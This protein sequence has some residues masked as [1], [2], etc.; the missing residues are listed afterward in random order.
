MAKLNI[1]I[2]DTSFPDSE[3]E[4]KILSALDANVTVAHCKTED[5]VLAITGD[6]DA[7][8]V[9]WA[10]ITRRVM[11]QMKHC[12]FISRYGVGVDMIDLE[13]A[14][15]LGIVVQN[16]PDFCVEEVASTTLGFLVAVGRKL[17]WQD[18]LVRQGKW[19]MASIIGPVNRFVGQTL[20][21]VGVG[22]IGMRFAEMAAPLKFKILAYDVKPPK[23]LGPV[24]IAD[25]D[26]VL[27]ESDYVSLHCP[28]TKD[29]RHLINAQTLAKM[30]KG[31]FLINVSRGGVVDT[32][33]LIDA[34]K[35]GHLAGAALDVFE[36]EPL[37]ADSP[38]LKLNNVIVAP[39]LASYSL[40]AAAQLRRD[41]AAHVVEYFQKK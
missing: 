41:V 36:Q 25:L 10:P 21:L 9:Q 37:P 16:V 29:T 17:V 28:L 18:Q 32:N 3:V 35:S 2:T 20:G 19:S 6:A 26:T 34:L 11:E 33:A 4:K 13:A 23:D 31:S 27:R 24:Q 39:H 40:D 38:I 12:K 1:V 8:M 22:R 15:D 7:L 14:K 30:K 5:E